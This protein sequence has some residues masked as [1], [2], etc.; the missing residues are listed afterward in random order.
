MTRTAGATAL[1]LLFACGATFA[2][3]LF[4][5][6]TPESQSRHNW[7]KIGG[8]C[9]GELGA[10]I[11]FAAI[12]AGAALVIPATWSDESTVMGYL[13]IG[14]LSLCAIVPVASALGVKCVG[15]RYDDG[16]KFWASYVGGLAGTAGACL[17]AFYGAVLGG[18]AGPGIVLF[19]VGMTLPSL[20]ATVGYNLSRPAPNDF[21]IEGRRF[22]PPSVSLTLASRTDGARS[23]GV[24]VRLLAVR[25]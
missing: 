9:L 22:L 4:P 19:A 12:T 18:A 5:Q 25:L 14:A 16:G 13:G 15:D 23:A 20:G 1:V 8:G 11:G 6:E 24:S 7:A 10:T 2:E 17:L 3:G 21:G